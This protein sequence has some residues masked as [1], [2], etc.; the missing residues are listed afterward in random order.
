MPRLLAAARAPR[1]RPA[2]ACGLRRKQN[3]VGLGGNGAWCA[4]LC[5]SPGAAL[6]PLPCTF[7]VRSLLEGR[8]GAASGRTRYG[9]ATKPTC[10]SGSGQCNQHCAHG[11][12]GLTLLTQEIITAK[13][14]REVRDPDREAAVRWKYSA[15]ARFRGPFGA[16][17]LDSRSHCGLRTSC[18]GR[19]DVARVAARVLYI[20][21]CPAV[22]DAAF[23]LP[24]SL[25]SIANASHLSLDTKAISMAEAAD[26]P[27]RK[28]NHGPNFAIYSVARVLIDNDIARELRARSPPSFNQASII[29]AAQI[30]YPATF[31]ALQQTTFNGSCGPSYLQM[32]RL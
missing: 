32:P 3:G 10:H 6:V 11:S 23:L 24:A 18:L 9:R 17:H 19:R 30:G 28:P 31:D 15:A 20:A 21:H 14:R 7:S 16:P 13:T 27:Q 12:H 29:H 2:P 5:Q 8:S 25:S 22:Y 26:T 4:A 1:R